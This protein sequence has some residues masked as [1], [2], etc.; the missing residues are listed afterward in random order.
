MLG[1]GPNGLLQLIVKFIF[2]FL[3]NSHHVLV[4]NG[5]IITVILTNLEFNRASRSMLLIGFHSKIILFSLP[6]CWQWWQLRCCDGYPFGWRRVWRDLYK[7]VSFL[8]LSILANSYK[9]LRCCSPYHPHILGF[10]IPCT[11]DMAFFDI[12]F[13]RL[14][15]YLILRPYFF[16]S[17][18]G[19]GKYVSNG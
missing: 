8:S 18:L 12:G 11:I 2:Y 4:H 7:A 9:E 10:F 15:V 3:L 16:L 17:Y 19:L 13:L 1:C 14:T 6:S 5:Y